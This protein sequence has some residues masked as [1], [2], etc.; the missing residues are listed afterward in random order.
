MHY[1]T[2][3]IDTLDVALHRI[4]AHHP[5]DLDP[6]IVPAEVAQRVTK[7]NGIV[8]WCGES[9]L[10]AHCA[11]SYAL[12]PFDFDAKFANM[13]RILL[14]HLAKFVTTQLQSQHRCCRLIEPC[15]VE[16]YLLGQCPL[17]IVESLRLT[18]ARDA[19]NGDKSYR[20]SVDKEYFF[21][22]CFV[23]KSHAHPSQRESVCWLGLKKEPRNS[24]I[25]K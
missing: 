1:L 10:G 2:E 5:C 3:R 7:H 23:V 20:Q 13:F 11:T 24:K 17:I 25:S 4:S 22:N 14:V 21:H 8:E 15:A 18:V 6:R 9:N 16:V 19:P 12:Q